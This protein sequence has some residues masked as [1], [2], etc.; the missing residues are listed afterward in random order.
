MVRFRGWAVFGRDGIREVI[1]RPGVLQGVMR[2]VLIGLAIALVLGIGWVAGGRRLTT[3]IDRMRTVR[4][5]SLPVTPL[6]YRDHS[7]YIGQHPVGLWVDLTMRRDSL[8]RLVVSNGGKEFTLGPAKDGG[9]LAAEPGDE[10]SFTI[11]HS[12]VSWP[13]PLEMN[14]M[15]G[16]SPSWKRYLYYQLAWKKQAGARMEIVWRYEQWFYSV[17]GWSGLGGMSSLQPT[18]LLRF[19]IRN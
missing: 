16:A 2:W 4:I 12:L 10:V 5:T 11:D 6:V 17:H 18:G 7:L 19:E 15:T 14:F 3:L 8:N 13:T 1:G 9:E